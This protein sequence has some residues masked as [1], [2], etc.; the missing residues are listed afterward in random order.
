MARITFLRGSGGWN[1]YEPKPGEVSFCW[2]FNVPRV[3]FGFVCVE[4]Y[5]DGIIFGEGPERPFETVLVPDGED[6]Q[7]PATPGFYVA[8][9]AVIEGKLQWIL[10]ATSR[11]VESEV[12]RHEDTAPI[13]AMEPKALNP[14]PYLATLAQN[15]NGQSKNGRSIAGYARNHWRV[16]DRPAIFP[17]PGCVQREVE[18]VMLSAELD[19]PRYEYRIEYRDEPG[20]Y[21]IEG[22]L[23]GVMYTADDGS[24]LKPHRAYMVMRT[25]V[26]GGDGADEA[27]KPPKPKPNI[28]GVGG[29]SSGE[30]IKSG[31]AGLLLLGGV[32]LWGLSRMLRRR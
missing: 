5:T 14:G 1:N 11:M 15:F 19:A 29:L 2:Q 25:P 23:C 8:G 10:R 18:Y 16:S 13:A 6:P 32:G 9:R 21:E 17:S 26:G 3:D 28:P 7:P 27:S 12:L 20:T 24:D 4:R 31:G 22:E 30:S